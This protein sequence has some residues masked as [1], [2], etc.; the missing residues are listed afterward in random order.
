VMCHAERRQTCYNEV[1][2]ERG[3]G[4]SGNGSTCA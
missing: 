3:R 2:P 4:G 1:H